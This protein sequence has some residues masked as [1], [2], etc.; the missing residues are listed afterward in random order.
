MFVVRACVRV[1]V[2]GHLLAF[3]DTAWRDVA[4]HVHVHALCGCGT[5]RD[6]AWHVHTLC[7]CGAPCG[8]SFAG[9]GM[10]S[11]VSD[12]KINPRKSVIRV[13]PVRSYAA[14]APFSMLQC[15]VSAGSVA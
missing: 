15:V 5:W 10:S 2:F 9:P 14:L 12:A 13:K 8:T 7:G 6:V 4:W 1:F 3:P 11:L